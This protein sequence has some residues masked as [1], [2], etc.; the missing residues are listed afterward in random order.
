MNILAQS[1]AVRRGVA[2]ACGV[3]ASLFFC[4]SAAA[5]FGPSIPL[6]NLPTLM[7]APPAG[8]PAT[9]ASTAAGPYYV[10]PVWGQT[11]APNVRFVILSNFNGDAVLDRT[12]GLVWARQNTDE[13][14]AQ[15]ALNAEIP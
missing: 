1:G 13:S 6:D 3:L 14:T 5:Q 2:V 10:P 15:I 7:P 9:V 4:G 8:Y 12:T 11:L